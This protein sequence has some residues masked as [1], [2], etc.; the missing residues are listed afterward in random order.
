[1]LLTID[2]GNTNILLGIF[3]GH[4]LVN[5]WRIRSVEGKTSD[6]Y[7]IIIKKLLMEDDINISDIDNAIISCVVPSLEETIS[8]TME[9]YLKTKPI[10]IGPGVKTGMPLLTDNPKEIGADRIVNAVAA[11]ATHKKALIVVD[12]G[13]AITF[14]FVSDKGEYKGGLIC[15][16]LGIATDALF[17][18][19]AKLP[20]V[21]VSKPEHV[22][23]KNTVESL[24]SGIFYG[25]LSMVE[26]IIGK[27]KEETK[28][29]PY[30]IATGGHS[31][32]IKGETDLINETDELLTL[33]GLKIIFELNNLS[34]TGK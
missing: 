26:G 19:T 15:P 22:V 9:K 6:E 12:F 7:G 18:K 20:R 30:V 10:V 11:Y 28:T 34:E 1:M 21:E 33:K 3:K 8:T 16:G 32:I 5:S 17:Q 13:T 27:I 25:Y 24:K 23:G 14:D 2:I 31:E 29:K 4:A